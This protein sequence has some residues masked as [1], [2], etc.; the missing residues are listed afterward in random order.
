MRHFS[1]AILKSLVAGIFVAAAML[2]YSA[3]PRGVEAADF[4]WCANEGQRCLFSGT[5]EV[6]YGFDGKGIT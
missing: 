4:V 5:A 3:S 2:S 6:L 1:A